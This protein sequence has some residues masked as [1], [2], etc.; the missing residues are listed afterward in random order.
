MTT[1]CAI[2][3]GLICLFQ[4]LDIVQLAAI[5]SILRARK[6]RI[7]SDTDYFDVGD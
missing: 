7:E 6:N 3:I 4:V 1:E 5:K 2:V